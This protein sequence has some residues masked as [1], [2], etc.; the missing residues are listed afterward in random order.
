MHRLLPQKRGQISELEATFPAKPSPI[1]IFYRAL[2]AAV[3]SAP[4]RTDSMSHFP[5]QLHSHW[6]SQRAPWY[7]GPLVLHPEETLTVFGFGTTRVTWGKEIHIAPL[8][9]QNDTTRHPCAAPSFLGSAGLWD[10]PCGLL[11]GWVSA[12]GWMAPLCQNVFQPL[13]L[14]FRSLFSSLAERCWRGT[15]S[16]LFFFFGGGILRLCNPQSEVN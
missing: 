12:E 3:P 7:M 6:L 2:P 16:F 13:L 8:D 14:L 9:L 11:I 4:S 15:F 1:S 5:F 10:F